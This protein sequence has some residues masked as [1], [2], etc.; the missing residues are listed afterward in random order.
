MMHYVSQECAK[1]RQ[2]KKNCDKD[3]VEMNKKKLNHVIKEYS[4]E[5]PKV[6]NCQENCLMLACRQNGHKNAC[7]EHHFCCCKNKNTISDNN[8]LHIFSNE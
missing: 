2:I 5:K 7:L 6:G 4:Y 3:Q 1:C 8:K